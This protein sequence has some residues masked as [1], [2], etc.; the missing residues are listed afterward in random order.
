LQNITH[1]IS[2]L[3]QA[4]TLIFPHPDNGCNVVL[5]MGRFKLTNKETDTEEVKGIMAKE[6]VSSDAWEEV[7]KDE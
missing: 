7:S 6:G 3:L 5:D 2:L 4:P 1:D